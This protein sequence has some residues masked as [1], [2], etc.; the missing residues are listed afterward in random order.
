M[1]KKE[2]YSFAVDWWSFGVLC[3]EMLFG[4]VSRN[5]YLL[6]CFVLFSSV[7]MASVIVIARVSITEGVDNIN[8]Q[9]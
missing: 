7:S 3:Y 9:L 1:I 6:F 4:E 5:I 8:I 2:N